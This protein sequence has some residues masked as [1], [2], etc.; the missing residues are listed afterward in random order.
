MLQVKIP[1][2]EEFLLEYLVMDFNGTMAVDGN[3]IPGVKER[4][5]KLAKDLKIYVVT[6]DTFGKVKAALKDTPCEVTI[7]PEGDQ[8]KAKLDFVKSL[9]EDRVVAFGNGRNDA[10]M[11]EAA[12]LGV[13]VLLNEGM[14]R[15]TLFAA[16]IIVPSIIDALD[17]LLNPL[18]LKATL[19]R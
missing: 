17:L 18:R 2:G 10:L 6:A 4:L 8:D 9:G 7:L 15:E 11:L 5:E 3:L 14:A 13:A 1:G 16:N 12:A 19:R